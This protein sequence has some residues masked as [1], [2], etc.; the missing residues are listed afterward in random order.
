MDYI[1]IQKITCSRN[2]TKQD[3]KQ[4]LKSKSKS[5]VKKRNIHNIQKGKNKLYDKQFYKH[6]IHAKCILFSINHNI[7]FTFYA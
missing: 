2:W 6:S 5:S 1:K 4:H 7:L 3:N